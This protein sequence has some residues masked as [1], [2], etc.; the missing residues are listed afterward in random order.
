MCFFKKGIRTKNYG[1][2]DEKKLRKLGA[3]FHK[4]NRGGLITFHGPGQLVSYPI[5]NLKNFNQGIRWYVETMEKTIIDL[6]AK[7]GLKAETTKD[8][9][10]W[11]GNK[12]ICAIGIHVSRYV[13]M[14]GLAFNCNVDLRWFEHIVPCGIEG[15]EVTS[16]SK[17]CNRKLAIE[18]VIPNFI[19]S[20]E[21]QFECEVTEMN[22]SQ[23]DEIKKQLLEST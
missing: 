3:E 10:V 9:G 18:N 22:Q 23:I 1:I 16:L 7:Y 13:T 5:I 2:E 17:E 4:T 8:T 6:C 12:K 15:K 11:I 20:F 19:S 21:S 14:H